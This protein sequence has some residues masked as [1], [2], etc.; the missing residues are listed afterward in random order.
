LLKF[1]LFACVFRVA[2]GNS[3]SNGHLFP[4]VN[5][6]QDQQSLLALYG[7]LFAAAAA[8]APVFPFPLPVGSRS[9]SGGSDRDAKVS[10][11]STSGDFAAA[12]QSRRYH[13]YTFGRWRHQ[14]TVTSHPPLG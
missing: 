7:R 8:A 5:L 3:H 10:P 11:A 1:G 4:V 14:T 9:P 12:P 2:D 13:P 6:L